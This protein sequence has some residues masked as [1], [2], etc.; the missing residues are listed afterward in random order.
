MVKLATLHYITIRLSGYMTKDYMKHP[1]NFSVMPCIDF[2]MRKKDDGM[3][4]K[5]D[6]LKNQKTIE[7]NPKLT[8]ENQNSTSDWGAIS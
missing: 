7:R 5:Y 6:D 4:T 3:K 1:M 2:R 8:N